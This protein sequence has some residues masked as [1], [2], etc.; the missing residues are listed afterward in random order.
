MSRLIVVV[1]QKKD[2]TAYYP[3]EDLLTFQEYLALPEDDKESR[4]QVINL[5]KSY[6]YLS[7]GYYCSLLAE[8][9][10]HHVIPS[11]RTLNNLRSKALYSLDLERSEEH[12]SELQSRENLVCRLLLEKKK[13]QNSRCQLRMY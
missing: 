7:Y 9:R 1:D 4:T 2:W 10:H 8:A 6:R 5:C 13:H 12:T 3:T 11:V